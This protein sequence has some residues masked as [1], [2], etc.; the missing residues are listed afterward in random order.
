MSAPPDADAFFRRTRCDGDLESVLQETKPGPSRA[1]G[2][3]DI[4]LIRCSWP[5]I[6]QMG[7]PECKHL[8][9]ALSDYIDGE[10][11]AELRIEIERHLVVCSHCRALLNTLHKT[12]SLCRGLPEPEMPVRTRERLCATLGLAGVL[13][14]DSSYHGGP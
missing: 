1:V 11:P 13:T 8:S 6:D 10:A 14:P 9:N 7:G 2:S 4:R 5:G 3:F 12:I